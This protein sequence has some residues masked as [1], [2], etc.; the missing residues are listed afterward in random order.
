MLQTQIK[1]ILNSN[2]EVVKDFR[3]ML[4]QLIDHHKDKKD[5]L[6]L[7]LEKDTKNIL[8]Q[9]EKIQKVKEEKEEFKFDGSGYE[10]KLNDDDVDKYVKKII[11]N[12]K[13]VCLLVERDS[14]N[15]MYLKPRFV[16][17]KKN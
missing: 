15:D 8:L 14:T 1:I 7:R 6:L 10:N 16:E 3:T 2:K 12:L 9:K 11:E 13:K 17:P 5:E 4:D